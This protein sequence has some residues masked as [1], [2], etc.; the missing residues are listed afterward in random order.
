MWYWRKFMKEPQTATNLK[1]KSAQPL[2]PTYGTKTPLNMER[3]SPSTQKTRQVDNS[4][5]FK[6][7][8]F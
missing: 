3:F 6:R 4:T 8:H 1:Q 7:I 5:Y 2:F